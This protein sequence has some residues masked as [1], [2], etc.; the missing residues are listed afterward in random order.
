MTPRTARLAALGGKLFIAALAMLATAV[1]CYLLLHQG[2][3][4]GNNPVPSAP[5]LPA[6]TSPSPLS[7]VH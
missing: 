3:T 4:G 2:S 1:F 7:I 5:L 6:T